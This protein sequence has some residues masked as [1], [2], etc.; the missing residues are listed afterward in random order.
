MPRKP[1]DPETQGKTAKLE[2][3][4]P[5]KLREAADAALRE[6]ETISQFVRA[7]MEVEVKRRKR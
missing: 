2:V 1:L 4:V 3:R 7:A 5:A 6:G